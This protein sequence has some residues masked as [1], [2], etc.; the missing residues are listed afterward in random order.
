MKVN[1][2]INLQ[3][4]LAWL[5][6]KWQLRSPYNLTFPPSPSSLKLV[7][8]AYLYLCWSFGSL[9]LWSL[10]G[11]RLISSTIGSLI[12]E[13]TINLFHLY[14]WNCSL[15][16]SVYCECPK[17]MFGVSYYFFRCTFRLGFERQVLLDGTDPTLPHRH[18][19]LRPHHARWRHR[20]RLRRDRQVASSPSLHRHQLHRIITSSSHRIIASVSPSALQTSSI[21]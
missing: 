21:T 4:L 16:L 2:L 18:P 11:Y 17:G 8:I 12:M 7:A 5:D 20:H 6:R 9:T 15:T 3:T 10:S 13:S 19:T 1:K 14:Y